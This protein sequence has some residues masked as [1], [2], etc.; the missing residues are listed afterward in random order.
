MSKYFSLKWLYF[1]A[2]SGHDVFVVSSIFVTI[3]LI[4][5]LCYGCQV[6]KDADCTV[7]LSFDGDVNAGATSTKGLLEGDAEFV[8]GLVGQA[9]RIENSGSPTVMRLPLS[10]FKLD[11]LHDFSVQ[12]WIRTTM[13]SDSRAVVLST[14]EM[15]DNSLESQKQ[16][17]WAFSISQGTWAWN[18]GSG[19]RRISYERS[20]GEFFKV[21]DGRWHQLAMTYDSKK[22]LIRLYFDGQNWVT[23]NVEDSGRFEFGVDH[24]LTVGWKGETQ[25]G[26]AW[27]LP[28]FVEGAA[29]LQE[30]VDQYAQIGLPQ[31]EPDELQRLVSRPGRLVAEKIAK[32]E[33]ASDSNHKTLVERAKAFDLGTI[34]SISKRLMRSP[35]TVHQSSYYN[36][37]ALLFQLYRLDNGKVQINRAVA[38]RLARREVLNR[39]S[40]DMD[41][42]KFW[43][44]IVSPDEVAESYSR[45]FPSSHRAQPSRQ[46]SL[47]AGSWNIYHGGLHNSIERDGFDSRQS[48]VDLLKREE[49]DVLMMQETY[50]SGDYV[51]AELGYYFATTIDWDNMHQG[52]NISVLSRYPIKDVY[53]PPKSTFMSVGTKVSLSQTQEIYVMSA[54]FGM[55][56]F[57]DVFDFHRSRFDESGSIPTLFAGDFNAVPHTDGGQSPAS[58]TLL[59]YGF[60]D[61]YR[62]LYP[63]VDKYPGYT[64]RS[65]RRIDQLYYK[66]AGLKSISTEVFSDWPSKF[67]SDHYLIKSVFELSY[68]AKK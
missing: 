5:S 4:S 62:S 42:L 28:I 55:R 58:E 27:E 13:S 9:I 65:N 60:A 20:N 41:E 10:E 59:N 2:K 66:G 53:V 45:F 50:S 22:G 35:Y 54:W 36:E 37:V 38:E 49:I 48:I 24:P 46:D 64:H 8:S 30:M 11:R 17:G 29:Q 25:Q 6:E 68:P 26:P 33:Q 18:A 57:E 31:L 14:K 44:R 43:D 3:F 39:P 32:L 40:F 23:Y 16:R 19:N 52:S 56:N 63:D 67:P 21:N 7:C 51:A 34:E 1:G 12:F 15:T 47:V 61:A